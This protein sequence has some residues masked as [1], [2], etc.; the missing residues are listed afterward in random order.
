MNVSLWL[1]Q[2]STSVN[3]L[4]VELILAHFLGVE[5]SFLHAH[6]ETELTEVQTTQLAQMLERR[7]KNEPLAYI[8][9]VKDFYGREFK[10]TKD[11][12]IP[13][14]ETE[15]LIE[16]AKSLNPSKILDVGTGSGC[17]A[18]T[19]AKELPNAKIT[20]VDISEKALKIAKENAQKHLVEIDFR[21]SNLLNGPKDEKYDLIVANLPY[22]DENWDWLSPELAFEPSEA[23]FALDGGLK[24]I[25]LLIQQAPKH[26]EQGGHLLLE[27]DR[28]QH[29]KI[30]D[31]ARKTGDFTP[32]SLGDESLALLLS[33]LV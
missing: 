9:G 33:L 10:V 5:R 26:L 27:A 8:T 3:R 16:V 31:Y 14:P 15:V 32:I 12:L 6:P 13:R 22:V 19:L 1:K 25:K 23:L 21:Q 4:D 24:L 17:I 28:T 20:G 7:A 2:A 30:T 29:Q 11:V 18:I